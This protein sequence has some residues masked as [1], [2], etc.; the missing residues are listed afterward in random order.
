MEGD[1]LRTRV[2]SAACLIIGALVL[3]ALSLLI[4]SGGALVAGVCGMVGI[5]AAFEVSRA[6]GRDEATLRYNPVRATLLFITMAA[7]VFGGQL[8]SL[9]RLAEFSAEGASAALVSGIGVGILA[10][11]V[12][13]FEEGRRNLESLQKVFAGAAPGLLFIPSAGVALTYVGGLDGG[14]FDVWWLALVVASNDIAAY[15]AGRHFG[16]PLLAPALSPKKTWS[17]SS[18]GLIAG[19]LVGTFFWPVMVDTTV[20][21]I[22]QALAAIAVVVGAQLGDLVKSYVKR[23]RGIKD[24]GNLIPGHGGVLDR[25]DALLGGAVAFVPAHFFVLGFQIFS[26]SA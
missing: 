21:V 6:F 11:S 9:A 26:K 4:S 18:A 3:S 12:L 13:I 19:L 22:G 2:I 5:L 8:F 17:G 10:L 16:G 15:F 20:T 23:C 14:I 24:F 7:P 1:P 25:F